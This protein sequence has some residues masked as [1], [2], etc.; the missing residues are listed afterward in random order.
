MGNNRPAL[1]PEAYYHIYNHG[2]GNENIFRNDENYNWFLKRY[3]DYISPIAHTFAY[4]LMP[5]HF[6]FL[7]QI[8]SID[9]INAH[10]KLRVKANNK[11]TLEADKFISQCFS[12]F[13]NSYAKAFNKMYNRKGS[14]FLDNIKRKAVNN[15][16]YFTKLIHYI[17]AN[18]VHHGF[19]NSV[20]AW[21]HSSYHILLSKKPTKLQRDNVLNWYGSIEEFK[22]IHQSP[23]TPKIDFSFD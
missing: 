12:N 15:D 16:G 11:E 2:N 18:P 22:R 1:Q 3:N 4:C 17:H 6:H 14:L 10:Y 9:E 23:I 20:E 5:N 21:Q 19:V 8:K 13:L 7:V